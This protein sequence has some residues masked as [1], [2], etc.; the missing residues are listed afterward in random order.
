MVQDIEPSEAPLRHWMLPSIKTRLLKES[1]LRADGKPT[2]FMVWD[3]LGDRLTYFDADPAVNYTWE[4]ENW[5]PQTK[6]YVPDLP[7]LLEGVAPGWVCDLSGFTEEDGFE[8]AI[9]PA[10]YGEYEV[11]LKDGTTHQARPVWDLYVERLQDYSPE[12]VAEICDLPAS[13]IKESALAYATRIDPASGFGNGGLQYMLANEP[14]DR[15]LK[16]AAAMTC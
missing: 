7:N 4:G 11:T 10:L 2:R 6:G 14:T 8:V 1:D 15:R 5:T 3:S 9:E 16:T 13:L 12:K